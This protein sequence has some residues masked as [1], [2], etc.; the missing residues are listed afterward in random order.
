[1]DQ[2]FYAVVFVCLKGACED[3]VVEKAQPLAVC[4]E[5]VKEETLKYK[6][7]DENAFG[8]C[9]SSVEYD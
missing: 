8:S 9:V 2:L 7:L 6:K 3:H 4:L 5:T 1:M